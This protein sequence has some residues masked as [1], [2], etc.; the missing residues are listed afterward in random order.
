MARTPD[1]DR[2]RAPQDEE[3]RKRQGMGS[4]PWGSGEERADSGESPDDDAH[5]TQ[6]G[7]PHG[8]GSFAHEGGGL[9]AGSG[10]EGMEFGSSGWGGQFGSG[11]P[12]GFGTSGIGHGT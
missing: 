8:P 5:L 10:T 11:M 3:R 2:Q 4:E 6:G 7:G 9:T 1:D 12:Q